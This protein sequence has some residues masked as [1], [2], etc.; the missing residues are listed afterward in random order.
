MKTTETQQDTAHGAPTY[1]EETVNTLLT[2]PL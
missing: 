1:K 2:K